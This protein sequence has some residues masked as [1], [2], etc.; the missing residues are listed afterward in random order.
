[1][2]SRDRLLHEQFLQDYVTPPENCQRLHIIYYYIQDRRRG[3][4]FHLG[5][6]CSVY[7]VF[8]SVQLPSNFKVNRIFLMQVNFVCLCRHIVQCTQIWNAE[9]SVLYKWF[10]FFL[11]DN[12]FNFVMFHLHCPVLT[13]QINAFLHK[14]W[15]QFRHVLAYLYTM[16]SICRVSNPLYFHYFWSCKLN[17]IKHLS[18]NV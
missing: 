5:I 13:L 3:R 4:R 12:S 10:V 17:I 2:V 18:T 8:A 14:S 7:H 9:N 16:H 6:Y 11:L 1:M 15:W